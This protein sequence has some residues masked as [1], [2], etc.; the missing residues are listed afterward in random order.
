MKHYGDICKL[1]G[2]ELPVVDCIVG[3]SPCQDLSVAGARAGLEGE[4]SSLVM[5][6]IRIVKEMRKHDRAIG[7]S[8]EY[9]RPRYMVWENV[10]GAFSSN[11]GADFQKVL[12]EIVRVAEPKAPD[13]PLP[14]KGKWPYSGC[15]CDELGRWS[16]AWRVH[17]AQYWG[18]PQ[19]RKRVSV[20]ADF[21]GLTA[22]EILFDPKLFRETKGSES[23]TSVERLGEFAGREVQ[24]Q[25]ESLSGNS[26]P[27]GEK[28]EGTT[29]STSGSVRGTSLN[30]WDVQSKHI[31]PTDGIAETLYSG[32]CRYGG[33][34]SYVCDELPR[35]RR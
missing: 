1:D 20:L 34:E 30:G 2:A 19:R 8:D 14:D 9:V 5:E 18:V 22:S 33:G 11:K 29:A 15:I 32:E 28:G 26:E 13:V 23:D 16:V 17:D 3:G 4:R 7:R 27:S 10:P 6:Q 24:S 31:Q 21:N 12:T 25:S 35:E